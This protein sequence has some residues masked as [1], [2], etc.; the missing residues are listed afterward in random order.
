MFH[1][2]TILEILSADIIL[3]SLLNLNTFALF[4][5]YCIPAVGDNNFR[6]DLLT[7]A[8]PN[9]QVDEKPI[10]WEDDAVFGTVSI[11]ELSSEGDP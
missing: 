1:Y 10:K 6:A 9:L 5:G 4:I 2:H 8:G 7:V 11:E 3:I